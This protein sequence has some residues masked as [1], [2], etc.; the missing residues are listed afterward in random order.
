MRHAF[1]S[2]KDTFLYDT[3]AFSPASSSESLV[4]TEVEH[5]T[6]GPIA[7]LTALGS[8]PLRASAGRVRLPSTSTVDGFGNRLTATAFGCTEGCPDGADETITTLT[9]PGRPAGDATGWLWR[10][11]TSQVTGSQYFLGPLKPTAFEYTPEGALVKTT[12]TLAHTLELI[13]E[14]KRPGV[15]VTYG[16]ADSPESVRHLFARGVDFPLV[17]TL[18]ELMPHAAAMGLEPVSRED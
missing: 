9:T 3:A 16:F 13:S 5:G 12:A 7:G 15:R 8:V 11:L 14:F 18:H 10:T 2:G 4:D 1:E 17:N 6:A